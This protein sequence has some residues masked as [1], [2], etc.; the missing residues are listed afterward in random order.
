[1][2]A[3]SPAQIAATS[4]DD[5]TTLVEKGVRRKA[6]G[7]NAKRVKFCCTLGP[8]SKKVETITAMIEAGLD[9]I[10]I[11]FSH[12][13]TE[14]HTE[15]F[16]MVQQAMRQAGRTITI[17]G[18]I[19]G[20]KLRIGVFEDVN[21]GVRLE[22]GQTFTLDH[23]ETPGTMERVYL[24]HKEFY[25]VCEPGDDIILSD[26][27]I[28]LQAT[29]VDRTGM[30]I[31]TKVKLGG[32]LG[33]RKG[34]AI[35]TRVLPLC[36]LSEKDLR[37]IKNACLLGVDWIALS[38]VQTKADVIEAREYIQKLHD[39]NPKSCLPRICSK[40][41]KPTAVLD[42]DEIAIQ[43]DMMM[44]ARG[45]L[46]IET[47]F[48]KVCSLQKY[49]CERARYHGCQVMV[50]TQVVE[51]LIKTI[52]PTR[53]EV[54][55]IASVCM[56]GANSILVSAETAAG[57]NPVNVVKTVRSVLDVVEQ[58][59]LFHK[60]VLTR[61]YVMDSDLECFRT[62]DAVSLGASILANE[63]SARALV[64]FTKSGIVLD[65][66]LRQM[67]PCPVLCVTDEQRTYQW[68]N[69]FWGCI[70]T[71]TQATLNKTPAL[72][73]VAEAQALQHK[74]VER[75]DAIVLIFETPFGTDTGA[76]NNFLVHYVGGRPR[77]CGCTCSKA[78]KSGPAPAK[79]EL[80]PLK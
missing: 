30:R 29:E 41:E 45:D 28:R 43:S 55:D 26:G 40:I 10:R 19:Q 77:C 6:S 20:P 75:G 25:A 15:I 5:L 62:L 72:I 14:D 56:D 37:D 78:I 13:N 49:I 39:E 66:V 71:L 24:P 64:V 16:G 7:T 70:P 58:T 42:I 1:M 73:E 46:A 9:A 48:S 53:A 59:E 65:R 22:E 12:G 76:S 33:S 8:A 2:C 18:D 47:C 52:V 63:V 68:T 57:C 17:L 23:D 67:P 79:E 36:G 60:A 4:V 54:T 69:I 32:V 44:V 74:L 80:T 27:Y 31:V 51:S 34:I 11:N 3:P 21:A 35:P 61:N 38:F 50:A